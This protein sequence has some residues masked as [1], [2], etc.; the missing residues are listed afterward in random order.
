MNL[1]KERIGCGRKL[2]MVFW[3]S[4]NHHN[5]ELNVIKSYSQGAKRV[6][7]LL[8]LHKDHQKQGY[9]ERNSKEFFK[10]VNDFISS[11]FNL[12]VNISSSQS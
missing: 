4:G 9:T 8:K 7:K 1:L 10:C 11:L 12:K 3:L 6:K 5:F 2:F